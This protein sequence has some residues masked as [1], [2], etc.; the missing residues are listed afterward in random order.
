MTTKLKMKPAPGEVQPM[1][2][3][4]DH[5]EDN[6]VSFEEFEYMMVAAGRGVDGGHHGFSHVVH[7]FIHMKEIATLITQECKNFV[8]NFSEKHRD[9]FLDL[10]T[11]N[12]AAVEQNPT[13]YDTFNIFCEE[14]ELTMQNVLM[15]WGA[16]SMKSFDDE[17]LDTV[18]E[19]GVLECFLKYTDYPEFIKKMYLTKQSVPGAGSAAA[20]RP[21]TPI[22]TPSA[23]KR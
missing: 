15:L 18:G 14:A 1:I 12:V 9:K 19:T 23:Q 5:D 13:W 10:P 3:A 4:V 22:S 11:D 17:F 2:I 7:R 6:A 8:E 21:E 16:G 20:V